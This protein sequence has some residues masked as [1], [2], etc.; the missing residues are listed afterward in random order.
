MVIGNLEVI[1]PGK[2]G[3]SHLTLK[4]QWGSRVGIRPG[5]MMVFQGHVLWRTSRKPLGLEDGFPG[6]YPLENFHLV[7]TEWV[8]AS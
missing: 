6:P 1:L 8:V 2:A 5:R 3:C 7:Y 4:R